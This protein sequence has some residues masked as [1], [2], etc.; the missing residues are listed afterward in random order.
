MVGCHISSA[1]DPSAPWVWLLWSLTSNPLQILRWVVFLRLVTWYA[2]IL[3]LSHHEFMEKQTLWP[4]LLGPSQ[5]QH[6]LNNEGT[7]WKLKQVKSFIIPNMMKST[8]C[9]KPPTIFFGVPWDTILEENT[10]FSA[11]FSSSS[12][13]MGS[14]S[15]SHTDFEENL[16]TRESFLLLRYSDVGGMYSTYCYL[17]KQVQLG[18]WSQEKWWDMRALQPA[19]TLKSLGLL[20]EMS[21]PCQTKWFVLG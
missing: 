17:W 19:T 21:V 7:G 15:Q 20:E 8:T 14:R 9:L 1:G 13:A 6:S 3:C 2:W 16:G 5:F 12:V 4:Q 10:L 11:A 18:R